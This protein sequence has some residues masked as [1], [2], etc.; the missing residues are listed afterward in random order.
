MTFVTLTLTKVKNSTLCKFCVWSQKH[1][2]MFIALSY[3]PYQLG[4]KSVNPENYAR[5]FFLLC[6]FPYQFRKNPTMGT[7][8]KRSHGRTDEHQQVYICDESQIKLHIIN[9]LRS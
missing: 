9:I 1:S 5:T 2:Y 8:S 6:I 3:P 4:A 7:W